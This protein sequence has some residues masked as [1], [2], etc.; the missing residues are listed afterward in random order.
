MTR[1]D[2]LDGKNIENLVG[3]SSKY[4]RC[5]SDVVW[6]FKQIEISYTGISSIPSILKI[7]LLKVHE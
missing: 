4:F 1:L 7:N 5:K 6:G 3:Y 2:E